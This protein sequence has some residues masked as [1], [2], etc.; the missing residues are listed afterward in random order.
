MAAIA[1][2]KTK[3][4]TKGELTHL[5]VDVKK[6][7][8]IIPMFN[9]MGLLPKTKFQTESEDAISIEELRMRVHKELKQLWNK[10]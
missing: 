5:I 9:E 1:G 10:K 4:N 7:A 8:S 2:I 6:H 3:K